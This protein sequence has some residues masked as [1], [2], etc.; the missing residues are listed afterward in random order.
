MLVDGEARRHPD[1]RVTIKVREV[2]LDGAENCFRAPG[3]DL[4]VGGPQLDS[5]IDLQMR[6]IRQIVADIDFAGTAQGE[7]A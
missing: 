6:A 2:A 1:S 4:G 3:R 5:I 7:K